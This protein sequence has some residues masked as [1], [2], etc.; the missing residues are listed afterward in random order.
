MASSKNTVDELV[1]KL[2]Q[3]LEAQRQFGSE[4]YP[5]S[6]QRL[7]ELTNPQAPAELV[8]KVLGN[9]SFKDRTVVSQK[10]NLAAPVALIED[11]D[12]L[13]SSPLL[14]EFLLE[15]LCSPEHPTCPPSKL[16]TKVETKLKKPLEVAIARQIRDNTLP[17]AVNFRLE[18]SKPVLF[19][20]RIPPPPP[21]KKARRN[22]GRQTASCAGSCSGGLGGNA[23]PL[24]VRRLVE[25]TGERIL[26][27]AH[28]KR[29]WR[30]LLSRANWPFGM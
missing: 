18:K 29:H 1:E 12:Q 3:G 27:R 21:P 22:S 23:Y 6:L 15:Q 4:A 5:L 20:R 25:L 8:E 30:L 26:R 10:K 16:K 28:S 13:A 19:L 14:L 7:V 24:S 11:L 9:K 2:L 17:L